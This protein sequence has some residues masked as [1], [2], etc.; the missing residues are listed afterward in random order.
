MV[1]LGSSARGLVRARA[2]THL[3]G[4]ARASLL[5][6]PTRLLRLASGQSVGR[7][8]RAKLATKLTR[9][10]SQSAT[11]ELRRLKATRANE[12][13]A[14]THTNGIRCAREARYKRALP[15]AAVVAAHRAKRAEKRERQSLAYARMA[16]AFIR[17]ARLISGAQ[18]ASGAR[19]VRSQERLMRANH[20]LQPAPPREKSSARAKHENRHEYRRE[21]L[22]R[23]NMASAH[24]KR[25]SCDLSVNEAAYSRMGK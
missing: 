1:A 3:G 20:P 6:T 10:R 4:C 8:R 2:H 18:S 16:G 24:A 23:S 17:R 25:H 9:G 7:T 5:I 11:A 15:C 22:A 13:R 19:A 12:A 14:R 21:K